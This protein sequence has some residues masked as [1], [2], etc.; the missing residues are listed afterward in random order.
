MP[1][2]PVVFTLRARV[3]PL[4]GPSTL[5]S[6][7]CKGRPCQKKTCR[8][9][10]PLAGGALWD[11]FVV[12]DV[13]SALIVLR[14]MGSTSLIPVAIQPA[15]EERKP[16]NDGCH[17]PKQRFVVPSDVGSAC[18]FLCCHLVFCIAGIQT[19][20]ANFAWERKNRSLKRQ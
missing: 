7:C 1:I 3:L 8:G 13:G 4:A 19:P 16:M 5:V 12:G 18:W 17:I 2:H 10:A 15:T 11:C 14:G 20:T 9:R 6:C